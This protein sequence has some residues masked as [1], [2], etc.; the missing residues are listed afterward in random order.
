LH[1]RDLPGR[2]D[3]VFSRHRV[4]VFV[5]G[6]LWHGNAW[7]VR[8]LRRI[9]DLFPSRTE[10][11]VAKIKRNVNRDR[12]VDEALSNAGWFSL[13]IWESDVLKDPVGAVN[14]VLAELHARDA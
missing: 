9:D 11:W 10:W 12:E 4:A 2:P 1:V 6:D 7:R 8:G 5:D 3:I 13:R 14:R